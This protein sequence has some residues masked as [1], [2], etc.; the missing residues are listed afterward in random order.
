MFKISVGY[1]FTLARYAEYMNYTSSPLN[2][3]LIYCN[4][5][6][7]DIEIKILHRSAYFVKTVLFLQKSY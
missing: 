3:L 1:D 6:C 2:T 5:L 4:F 7:P